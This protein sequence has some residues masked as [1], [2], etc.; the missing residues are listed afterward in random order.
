M[1]VHQKE[2]VECEKK[3]QSVLGYIM[4]EEEGRTVMVILERY[5][6]REGHASTLMRRGNDW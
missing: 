4:E 2:N 1:G 5:E 6:R 3:K